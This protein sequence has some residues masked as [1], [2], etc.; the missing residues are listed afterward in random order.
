MA[1][2]GPLTAEI[3]LPV[4]S[5]PGNFNRFH[6]MASLV[7]RCRSSEANQTLHD[8]WPSPVLVH[9]IYMLGGFCP[10]TE[11]F[12]VQNCKIHFASKSCIL[13]YWQH[14]CTALQQWASAKLC[15][16]VQGMELRNFR[17]IYGTEWPIMCWCAVNKLLAHSLSQRVPPI[18]DWTAPAAIMLRIS[19]HF[20]SWYCHVGCFF[21]LFVPY[22]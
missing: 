19:P 12:Y 14:Y 5:T 11:F 7:H 9:C 21:L 15:G 8:L 1:N 3:G 16:M 18:F 17:S 2:V 10:L 6:V 20:T 4:W 13:P 22:L